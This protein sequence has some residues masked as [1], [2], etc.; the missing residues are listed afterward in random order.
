[1]NSDYAYW[2][3]RVKRFGE[4]SVMDT[5]YKK[6]VYDTT[7]RKY[8]F[9][10]TI[11][12][13][14]GMKILDVGCGV[15]DWCN[16]YARAGCDV[17]GIDFI[18]DLISIAREN[19]RKNNLPIKYENESVESYAANR[20][21]YDMVTSVTVLQHI[22][23][24]ERFI[25]S[26]SNIFGLLKPGGIAVIIEYMPYKVNDSMNT[27]NYMRH[28]PR[29]KWIRYFEESGFK[30]IKEQSVRVLGFKL[31]NL[32]RFDIVL[33]LSLCID[34]ILTSCDPLFKRYADTRL[35]VLK[36]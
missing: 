14:R 28:I 30:L 4:R 10:K 26:I 36:K 18:N 32:F 15:G 31:Y 13:K 27:A 5:D 19:A 33:K 20:E 11:T 25:K 1:M 8:V 24:K 7:L 34:Q 12:L 21:H 9:S 23:D 6:G 35:L 16:D 3:D 22:K 2:I 29:S 17:T